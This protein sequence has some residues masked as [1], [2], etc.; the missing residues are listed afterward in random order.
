[1]STVDD[2]ISLH[3]QYRKQSGFDWAHFTNE[4]N[5]LAGPARVE[6]FVG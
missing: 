5:E 2:R 6:V 3:Y 4:L 1:M